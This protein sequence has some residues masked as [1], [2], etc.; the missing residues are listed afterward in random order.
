MKKYKR[1]AK[2]RIRKGYTLVKLAKKLGI[3][4]QYLWD[5]ED[6]R[7]NLSYKM[8]Y[9]ISKIL[10]CSPDEIFLEDEKNRQ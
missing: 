4:K 5:I 8:A 6:G 7:R 10:E 1:L 2:L 3:T 9:N